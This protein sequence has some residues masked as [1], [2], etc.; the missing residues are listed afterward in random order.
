MARGALR[1]RLSGGNTA[2]LRPRGFRL[3]AYG[4]AQAMARGPLGSRLSDGNTTA[5]LLARAWR[6]GGRGR[7]GTLPLEAALDARI[8]VDP[9]PVIR[10]RE[11]HH[12]R[13]RRV[14][15]HPCRP[16]RQR[17]SRLH[18]PVARRRR[19][20]RPQGEGLP[21]IGAVA[22]GAMN[23]TPAT[24]NVAFARGRGGVRQIGSV[25]FFLLWV[26]EF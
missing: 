2:A 7:R 14:L 1:S 8:H 16:W 20:V 3:R 4:L 18:A 6:E 26:S 23:A 13:A 15:R 25:E 12:G 9:A 11:L 10:L 21:M 17:R 24:L 22:A 5:L 19:Q